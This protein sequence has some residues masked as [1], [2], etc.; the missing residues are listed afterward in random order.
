PEVEMHV[1]DG[2]SYFRSMSRSTPERFDVV[3]MTL[4]DTWAATAA[5]A[6]ALSENNLY[7]REAFREYFQ[8]LNADGILAITRWE[9]RRPR[10]AMR[11]VSEAIDAL[12]SLG[13]PQKEIAGHF[14]VVSDGALDED[15]ISVT[16]LAKRSP[17]TREENA[18]VAAHLWRHENLS[19]LYLPGMRLQNPFNDLITVREDIAKPILGDPVVVWS[20][21][22]NF[23]ARYPYNISP[24]TDDAPF[25][26]FTLKTRDVLRQLAAGETRGIDWKNNLGVVVLGILLLI[27]IAAVLLFLILPLALV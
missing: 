10:E 1:G 16:V 24:V 15:G 13:V 22:E 8:H 11:V 18:S 5:G 4:V 23:I 12:I 19:L 25:F 21:R 26:F 9:F 2:R 20:E 7:T 14:A 6:F 27:S 3:Q 17:F